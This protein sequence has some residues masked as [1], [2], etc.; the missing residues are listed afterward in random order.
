MPTYFHLVF[1]YLRGQFLLELPVYIEA[2]SLQAAQMQ[3]D[4]LDDDLGR[5]FELL[6]PPSPVVRVVDSANGPRIATHLSK[7]PQPPQVTLHLPLG[8]S[9]R[10]HQRLPPGAP[11]A[12][13]EAIVAIPGTQSS[14]YQL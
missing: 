8:T 14:Y 2:A 13:I 1:P 3:A 10:L 5:K 11:L 4:Q 12:S 9:L 7:L 6:F